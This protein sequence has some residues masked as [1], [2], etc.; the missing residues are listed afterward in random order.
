MPVGQ[1]RSLR[2]KAPRRR[3]D[4]LARGNLPMPATPSLPHSTLAQ[5]Q[6]WLGD[7]SAG[8]LVGM[9][10][11]RDLIACRNNV[12]GSRIH[13]MDAAARMALDSGPVP[14][15]GRTIDL[16]AEP[17][18]LPAGGRA[19]EGKAFVHA[20]LLSSAQAGRAAP[21]PPEYKRDNV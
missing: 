2:G 21:R 16:L 12:S 11:V 7:P 1:G 3:Q 17:I 10:S 14:T 15:L 13:D 8:V 20:R 18:G 5:R 6:P 9:R 4:L 19:L